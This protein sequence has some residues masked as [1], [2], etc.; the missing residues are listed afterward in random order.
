MAILADPTLTWIARLVLVA[1]LAGA[2][3]AKLRSLEEFVGVVA[4]YRL[5]PQALVRPV[6]YLLPP[7][8]LVLAVGLIAPGTR[9][10]PAVATAALLLVFA[11]AMAVNIARGRTQIDCGCFASSL[12]QYLSWTLVGRNLALVALCALAAVPTGTRAVTWLD[13]VT[14]VAATAAIAILYAAISRLGA[15]GPSGGG[16]KEA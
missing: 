12:K 6:A 10:A 5:L 7:V 15:F 1:V 4:N 8:E 9:P 16:R 14:V 13:G 3:V 11:L 2:A